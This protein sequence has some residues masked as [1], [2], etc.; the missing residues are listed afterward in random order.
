VTAQFSPPRIALG[1]RAQY[2]VQIEES[3]P[4][5]RPDAESIDSL[6]IPQ[7]SGLQ[8]TNRRTSLAQQTRVINGR[9][10]QSVTQQLVIDARASSVGRFTVP[11]FS[12]DYK[13][14]R[15]QVPA[16]T[17]EVIDRPAGAPP[18]VDE[19]IFLKID[20]PESLYLGQTVQIDLQLFVS[21]RVRLSSLNSFD[22]QADGFTVSELPNSRE[23]YEQINGRT[24][25]ILTWPLTLT[26][27]RTGPQTMDFQMTVTARL[28]DR[29]TRR[30]PFGGSGFSGSIFDDI[31]G[32]A[33]RF[34][35]FTDAPPVDILALPEAGKPASFGG[36]IGDFAMEVTADRQNA[37]KGEPI[38][39]SVTISGRGNFDR[40]QAP[41]LPES[42]DWRAYA[43]EASF[44]PR[45]EGE[46]L[47][48]S[49]R[50][51]YVLIPQEIG[52]LNLPPVP[53]SF[54]DP[55]AK[56]YETLEAPP[57]AVTVVP[58]PN[59][60]TPTAPNSGT[61]ARET[62]AIPLAAESRPEDRLLAL[63]Y[64]PQ[65]I[66]STPEN[67]LRKPGFWLIQGGLGLALIGSAFYLRHQRR[68][69][70]EPTYRFVHQARREAPIAL[71]RA[72]KAVDLASFY[73]PALQLVRLRVSILAEAD[74]RNATIDEIVSEL[75]TRS[76]PSPVIS[77]VRS[78]FA[79]ADAARFARGTRPAPLGEEK[80]KLRTIIEAL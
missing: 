32:R 67:L 18:P 21:D 48:G 68:L 80:N 72:Q 47:R 13:G 5:S 62:T 79:G 59:V 15:L 10:S 34:T 74:L 54:F 71:K 14:Q 25:R 41:E 73:P 27:I 61:A 24:Y 17:L 8:L 30:G 2:V 11:A 20:A 44:Q 51:D 65:K 28:P 22:R 58:D 75:D 3:S 50:F 19:L 49:K 63:D 52:T 60:A 23:S 40:I 39:L 53:F 64:R 45:D 12:F 33:E 37:K 4:Q 55:D 66:R 70:D 29:Q 36:A 26:P 1:D 6:P 78:L 7:V 56:D 9:V 16:A 77:A 46:V 43:P 31:F 35:L 42:A 76:T 38:M 57:I 69:R